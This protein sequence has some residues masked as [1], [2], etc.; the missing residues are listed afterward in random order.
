MN[1]GAL[2]LGIARFAATFGFGFSTLSRLRMAG[3]VWV[4]L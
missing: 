2:G 4:F 3:G 1:G